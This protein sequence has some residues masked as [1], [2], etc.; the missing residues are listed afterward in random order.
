MTSHMENENEDI[1]TTNNTTKAKISNLD[2]FIQS[3]SELMLAYRYQ[4]SI[5]LSL[6]VEQIKKEAEKHN[7]KFSMQFTNSDIRKWQQYFCY[8]FDELKKK[9]S[10]MPFSSKG[11][12]LQ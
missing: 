12:R 4:K 1:N 6:T 3:E 2:F 7:A 11:K 10:K 5:G 8:H 9:P